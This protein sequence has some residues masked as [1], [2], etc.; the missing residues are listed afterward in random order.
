MYGF[1][2]IL[3]HLLYHPCIHHT[4]RLL[5]FLPSR[6]LEPKVHLKRNEWP[7]QVMFYQNNLE[8]QYSS[9]F[10]CILPCTNWCNIQDFFIGLSLNS[11]KP[12]AEKPALYNFT[13]KYINF[14]CKYHNNNVCLNIFWHLICQIKAIKEYSLCSFS[15]NLGNVPRFLICSQVGIYLEQYFRA[16]DIYHM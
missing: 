3:Y 1:K 5:I 8:M 14:E 11:G 16:Q 2:S 10:Y 12:R 9:L 7:I 13:S 15:A 4:C 6:S